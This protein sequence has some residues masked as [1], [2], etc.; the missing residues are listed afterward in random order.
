MLIAGQCS[1]SHLLYDDMHTEWRPW[2]SWHVAEEWKG[3]RLTAAAANT[4]TATSP[5]GTAAQ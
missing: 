3:R 2:T 4:V 5:S 1:V